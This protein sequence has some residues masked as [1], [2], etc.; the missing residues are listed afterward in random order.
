MRTNHD[1]KIVGRI[2]ESRN[3]G[4]SDKIMKSA[5]IIK[6]TEPRPPVNVEYDLKSH[7]HAQTITA[8]EICA[9]QQNVWHE[10]NTY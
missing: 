1:E 7:A 10:R 9:I 3:T 2:M 5:K 6:S 4:L 8:P